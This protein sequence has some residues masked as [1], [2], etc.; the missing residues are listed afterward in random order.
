MKYNLKKQKKE[1][2][3]ISKQTKDPEKVKK[4]IFIEKEKMEKLEMEIEEKKNKYEEF[5]L[6][7][8]NEEDQ[9]IIDDI[10][11]SEFD[12]EAARERIDRDR[13]SVV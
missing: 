5:R 2:A 8:L 7:K 10:Y 1:A 4:S 12:K 9:A 11:A 13:K 6:Q 3:A